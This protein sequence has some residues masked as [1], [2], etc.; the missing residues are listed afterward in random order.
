MLLE[1]NRGQLLKP[2]ERMKWPGQSENDALLS[3]YLM[4]K[5][6]L[7]AIKSNIA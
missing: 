2:P 5:V 6:K 3:R 4:V 7:D 1:K